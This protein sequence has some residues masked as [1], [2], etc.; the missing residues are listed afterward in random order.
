MKVMMFKKKAHWV[1][2][3]LALFVLGSAWIYSFNSPAIKRRDSFSV[4]L[5][6]SHL[7]FNPR[8]EI[9]P[10]PT[11]AQEELDGILTQE[12]VYLGRGKQCFAFSDRENK[13]VLKFLKCKR[14]EIAP[15]LTLLS[16]LP[17][18]KSAYERQY[19]RKTKRIHELFTSWKIAMERLQNETGLVFL[20]L[21][22]TNT[23][24]KSV[25]IIDHKGKD[26]I[27]NLDDYLFCIQKKATPLFQ[28]IEDKMKEGNPEEAMQLI[29]S[30]FSLIEGRHNKGII[31]FDPF[32][33][34]NTG[35][36]QDR[37]IHI[38]IGRFSYSPEYLSEKENAERTL[39]DA[40]QNLKDWL[41]IAYPELN[42]YLDK[43]LKA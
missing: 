15:W 8:W 35:F 1:I 41:C 12:F 40:M 37:A 21:N 43:R 24:Q 42:A 9:T 16:R 28:T 33:A 13:Y 22:K 34:H 10:L 2:P 38:D 19:Q 4:A 6:T 36:L 3:L 17:G 11:N 23:L 31:D 20:H 14:L 32:L 29:D 7:P 30:V 39:R 5:I 27:I 18:F 25:K 26:H